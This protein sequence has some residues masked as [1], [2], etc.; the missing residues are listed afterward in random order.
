MDSFSLIRFLFRGWHF[1]FFLVAAPP[2]LFW[3][4]VQAL[5]PASVKDCSVFGGSNP[6]LSLAPSDRKTPRPVAH[7]VGQT[8]QEKWTRKRT[9]RSTPTLPLHFPGGYCRTHHPLI[10]GKEQGRSITDLTLPLPDVNWSLPF[11]SPNCSSVSNKG[12]GR[13]REG[14]IWSTLRIF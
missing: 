1:F 3:T 7:T 12:Q 8:R 5:G 2:N 9:G 4:Y 14:W 10:P 6:D 11:W 13:S